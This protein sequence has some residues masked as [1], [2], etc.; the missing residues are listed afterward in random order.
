MGLPGKESKLEGEFRWGEERKGNN[1]D[2]RASQTWKTQ[3]S[4]TYRKKRFKK[5]SPEAKCR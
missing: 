3:E 5:K 1:G 2:A 4:R